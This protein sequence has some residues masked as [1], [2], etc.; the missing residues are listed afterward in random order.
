MKIVPTFTAQIYMAGDI[1]HARVLIRQYVFDVGLC[2]TV[3]PVR[4]IYTGGEEKGFRIGLINYPRFP[5]EP[6]DIKARAIDLAE[7][8]QVKLAARSFSIVMP[9]ETLWSSRDHE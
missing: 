9:D 1:R 3:E 8:L 5:S 6:S 7:V 4:Y 2:V